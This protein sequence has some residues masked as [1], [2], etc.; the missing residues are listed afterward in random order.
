MEKGSYRTPPVDLQQYVVPLFVPHLFTSP[1]AQRVGCGPATLALLTGVPPHRILPQNRKRHY[2]DRFMV[3]FL[4]RHGF[5]VL[6]LTQ[7]LVSRNATVISANHLVLL[8]QL[9]LPNEGSW[10]VLFGG[11][12]Y[13]NFRCYAFDELSLLNKPLLSA[14][15]LWDRTFPRNPAAPKRLAKLKS[16]LK[17]NAVFPE[18]RQPQA[19][20]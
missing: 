6:R 5:E 18:I 12:Y 19:P 10:G 9:L 2:S 4:R 11:I 14:Y 7:C 8:S 17:L 3:A 13:H 16:H 20:G 15:L 1:L